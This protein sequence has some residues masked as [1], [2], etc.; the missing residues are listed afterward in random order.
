MKKQPTNQLSL[1]DERER[2]WRL[3]E[4]TK[5]R[6]KAGVAEARAI[7]RAALARQAQE[8]H[9]HPGRLRRPTAA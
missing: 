1:V 5:E 8:Q 6:G 7:V 3:D 2:P 4:H 9:D